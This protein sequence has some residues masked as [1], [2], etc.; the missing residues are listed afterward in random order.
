MIVFLVEET[1]GPLQA[2]LM[3]QAKP[4]AT[5]RREPKKSTK[6]K[7]NDTP[8]FFFRRGLLFD[9][10]KSETL[11][12][13]RRRFLYSNFCEKCDFKNFCILKKHWILLLV[14]HFRF[15]FVTAVFYIFQLFVHIFFAI[16]LKTVISKFFAIWKNIGFCLWFWN[17]EFFLSSFVFQFLQFFVNHFSQS[18]F[19]EHLF[20]QIFVSS[21]L[22][23]A[24]FPFFV[25]FLIYLLW[26]PTCEWQM[27]PRGLEPRT[28]RLLAV[29]SNQL[30]Y[31]TLLARMSQH[32]ACQQKRILRCCDHSKPYGWWGSNSR[33]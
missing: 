11:E 1:F 32:V 18:F 20:Q 15:F 12:I 26:S 7:Q 19:K 14:L 8:Q 30:S 2:S 25:A 3:L 16:L 13:F 33:S 17:F 29:R 27:V 28:L 23:S 22:L 31:E 4:R 21:S 5:R 10:W 24:L 6:R 9:K